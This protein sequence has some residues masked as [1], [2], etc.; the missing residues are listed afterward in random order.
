MPLLMRCHART[1]I[2]GIAR[3]A[4]GDLAK[5]SIDRIYILNHAMD[6]ID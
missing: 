5:R 2:Q 1:K 4:Y 6:Q 3:N